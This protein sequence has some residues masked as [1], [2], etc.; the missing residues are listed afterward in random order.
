MNLVA[1]AFI[2]TPDSIEIKVIQFGAYDVLLAQK[3]IT[4]PNT[5][6][7]YNSQNSIYMLAVS[8]SKI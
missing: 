7:Q 6:C 1:K 3:Y 5:V 4:S 2:S 8:N